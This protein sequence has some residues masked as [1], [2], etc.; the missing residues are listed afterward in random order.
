MPLQL[1]IPVIAAAFIG[2]EVDL[3]IDIFGST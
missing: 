3:F 2:F 1:P